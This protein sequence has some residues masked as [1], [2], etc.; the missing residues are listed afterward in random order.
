L[1]LGFPQEG[2]SSE[3][4]GAHAIV[5]T[6][7]G[8]M[9]LHLDDLTPP[10]PPVNMSDMRVEFAGANSVVQGGNRIITVSGAKIDP[11][12]FPII[13]GL[14]ENCTWPCEHSASSHHELNL[15]DGGSE[16]ESE[17]ESEP[18]SESETEPESES[19]SEPESESEHEPES[20][21]EDE[22]AH[23]ESSLVVGSTTYRYTAPVMGGKASLHW[24]V[25]DE[26]SGTVDLALTKAGAGG[27]LSLAMPEAAGEMVGAHA[28]V[29]EGTAVQFVELNSYEPPFPAMNSSGMRVAFESA[30]SSVQDGE[31]ILIVSGA[32]L[33]LG[34]ASLIFGLNDGCAFPC[35]HSAHGAETMELSAPTSD[36]DGAIAGAAVKREH[37]GCLAAGTVSL[38]CVARL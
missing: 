20:E 1:G 14:H 21:P 38:L 22:P 30:S 5:A 29:A 27:W 28:I 4:I 25:T 16:A 17:S 10:F 12:A 7:S 18:E 35:E 37:V 26:A 13:F 3:M 8:M 9:F 15:L 11:M 2:S 33:P 36:G 34:S 19:E 24:V 32:K 31:T 23:A 6:D